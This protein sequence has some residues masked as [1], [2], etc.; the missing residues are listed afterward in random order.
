MSNQDSTRLREEISS[1][2]P[3][4][5]EQLE[6]GKLLSYKELEAVMQVLDRYTKEA[7]KKG[8]IAGGIDQLTKETK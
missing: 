8:Y 5:S 2:K 6:L 4:T 3:H 7:Y 1:L